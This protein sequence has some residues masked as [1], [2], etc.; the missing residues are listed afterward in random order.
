MCLAPKSPLL[1]YSSNLNKLCWLD[2]LARLQWNQTKQALI[3][4]YTI[5][6]HNDGTVSPKTIQRVY[7][8]VISAEPDLQ[9]GKKIHTA[10]KKKKKQLSRLHYGGAKGHIGN[11]TTL[12]NLT[13][14]IKMSSCSR[15]PGAV[16]SRSSRFQLNLIF[17]GPP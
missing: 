6:F 5:I 8:R 17:K 9:K 4:D 10:V 7:L 12:T 3:S 15:P 1:T 2:H 13:L 16:Q 11:I 14:T